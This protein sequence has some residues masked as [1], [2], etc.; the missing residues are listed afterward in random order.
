MCAPALSPAKKKASS[1]FLT[2]LFFFFLILF[3]ESLGAWGTSCKSQRWAAALW[4][5]WL[6]VCIHRGWR[7]SWRPFWKIWEC[8]EQVSRR[9]G[10]SFELVHQDTRFG[11]ETMW[12]SRVR[13][14]PESARASASLSKAVFQKWKFDILKAKLF[15]EERVFWLKQVARHTS[16]WFISFR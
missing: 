1:Y 15:R 12:K 9:A 5:G 13:V 4:C 16:H 14:L 8:S 3:K 11:K 10:E 6:F 7:E 2:H